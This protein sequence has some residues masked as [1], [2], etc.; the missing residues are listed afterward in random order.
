MDQKAY[1]H[2]SDKCGKISTDVAPKVDWLS[3][4]LLNF[5]SCYDSVSW[6]SQLIGKDDG[7]D[8]LCP[9]PANISCF[10]RRPEDI[11]YLQEDSLQTRLKRQKH[12]TLKTLSTSLHKNECF[13]GDDLVTQL[14]VNWKL[15]WNTSALSMIVTTFNNLVIISWLWRRNLNQLF[16][17][18]SCHNK[19]KWKAYYNLE[20]TCQVSF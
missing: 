13:N 9:N 14:C 16:F 18:I 19:K 5:S 6:T 7:F 3:Y 11:F 15:V 10:P 8:N 20:T 1:R 17:L 2:I 4:L 12:V